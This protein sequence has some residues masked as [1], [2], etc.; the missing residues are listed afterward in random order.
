MENKQIKDQTSGLTDGVNS[1]KKEIQ[2]DI[3]Q[4]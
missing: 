2:G 3:G 4:L 1:A